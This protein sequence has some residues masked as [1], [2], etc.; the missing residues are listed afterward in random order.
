MRY[1][2]DDIVIYDDTRKTLANV[3]FEDEPVELTPGSVALLLEFFL[4]HPHRL[5]SKE[6]IGQVAFV[7]SLYSASESNVNKSLSLLRRSF[8]E[9]GADKNIITTVPSVGV[10]FNGHV[11]Y[12]DDTKSISTGAS[13]RR[14]KYSICFFLVFFAAWV[15]AFFL[16][17][18]YSS[19]NKECSVLSRGD[20]GLYAKIKDSIPLIKTCR[21]PGIIINGARPSENTNKRY[22]LVAICSPEHSNCINYIKK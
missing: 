20:E 11:T 13:F 7:G 5:F 17:Y 4:S 1:L 9:A 12:L 16:Y 14:K 21:S 2:I 3:K 10:I 19:A 22:S 15:G 18:Y 6:D 8:M